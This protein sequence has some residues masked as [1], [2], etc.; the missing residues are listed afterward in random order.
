MFSVLVLDNTVFLLN[1]YVQV[2]YIFLCQKY[3]EVNKNVVCAV[4]GALPAEHGADW[5]PHGR[6]RAARPQQRQPRPVSPSSSCSIWIALSRERFVHEDFDHADGPSTWMDAWTIFYWGWWVSWSPFVGM[7]IAKISR[8]R[9]VKVR[10]GRIQ[11][12]Y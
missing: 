2:T 12:F 9:T 8:G 7:F 1:L 4:F 10:P 6:I 3:L 11:R 5:L